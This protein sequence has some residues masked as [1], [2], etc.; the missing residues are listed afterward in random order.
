[1]TDILRRLRTDVAQGTYELQQLLQTDDEDQVLSPESVGPILGAVI[2]QATVS[3]DASMAKPLLACLTL[4]LQRHPLNCVPYATGLV[5]AAVYS[6][7]GSESELRQQALEMLIELLLGDLY[8]VEEGGELVGEVLFARLV[9]VCVVHPAWRVQLALCEFILLAAPRVWP[10]PPEEPSEPLQAEPLL[11]ALPSLL[12]SAH[13]E[14]G[15]KAADAV[16]CLCVHRSNASSILD[17]LMRYGMSEDLLW[18]LRE[19]IEGGGIVSAVRPPSPSRG[20]SQQFAAPPL[21][22]QAQQSQAQ[23][24]QSPVQM[25]MQM[26]AQQRRQQQQQQQFERAAEVE[27]QDESIMTP[28][29]ERELESELTEMV[30]M[31][32]TIDKPWSDRK[33][34]CEQIASLVKEHAQWSGITQLIRKLQ[35]KG[36]LVVQFADLRSAIVRASCDAAGDI[37]EALGQRFEPFAMHIALAATKLTAQGDRSIMS[38]SGHRVI[39]RIVLCTDFGFWR[40]AKSIA[41]A[42]KAAKQDKLRANCADFMALLLQCWDTAVLEKAKGELT[43][44]VKSAICDSAASA[45]EAGRAAFW[46]FERHFPEVASRLGDSLPQSTFRRMQEGKN[47]RDLVAASSV[48]VTNARRTSPRS[49]VGSSDRG[50]PSRQQQRGGTGRRGR[51]SGGPPSSQPTR[52]RPSPQASVRQSMVGAEEEQLWAAEQQQQQQQQSMSGAAMGPSVRLT[53]ASQRGRAS[54]GGAARRS[55]E[56]ASGGTRSGMGGAVRVRA[57]QVKQGKQRKQGRGPAAAARGDR[58][59]ASGSARGRA[60]NVSAARDAATEEVD[61]VELMAAATKG[62]DWLARVNACR[63]LDELFTSSAIRQRTM[64][65]ANIEKLVRSFESI[66]TDQHPKVVQAG[67]RALEALI[68]GYH[69]QME[70][71][72]EWTLPRVFGKTMAPKPQ[73]RSCAQSL[74]E[75]CVSSPRSSPRISLSLSLSLSPLYLVFLSRSPFSS[76]SSSSSRQRIKLY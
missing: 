44:A 47:D 22:P 68:R 72:L 21:P 1:M 54:S 76:L 29:D 67:I 9:S 20:P 61:V 70:S 17:A 55:A 36:A 73:T 24:S 39:E 5:D 63:G 23:Q 16:E 60:G 57:K 28:H 25:Q 42:V 15:A 2:E 35:I 12:S 66:V 18:S 69:V 74:L 32:E 8:D 33:D 4:L 19:R 52:S 40:M 64:V 31:I 3:R 46:K 58:S 27:S 13:A 75:W 53:G 71:Q 14:V 34:A 56:G 65:K 7:Q 43:A 38:T 26:Q 48:D 37:A 30:E 11:R 62:K 49:R 41:E 6:L 10:V 51:G 50:A 59:S 45:R